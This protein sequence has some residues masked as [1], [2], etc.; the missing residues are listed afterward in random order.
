MRMSFE[1]TVF[2]VIGT[3]KVDLATRAFCWFTPPR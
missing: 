3:S 2:T 1:I